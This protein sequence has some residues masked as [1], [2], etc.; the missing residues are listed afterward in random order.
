M[1]PGSD[2]R[3]VQRRVLDRDPGVHFGLHG[4][5]RV[6]G[7]TVWEQWAGAAVLWWYVPAGSTA[8]HTERKRGVRL[9]PDEPALPV[10]HGDRHVWWYLPGWAERESADLP[11]HSWNSAV[12]LPVT[13]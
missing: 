12:F 6:R 4:Y 10:E 7:P 3:P 1:R 8:V 13:A 5:L 2:D 11:E 9:Q